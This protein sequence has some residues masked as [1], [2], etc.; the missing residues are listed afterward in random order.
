MIVASGLS[1]VFKFVNERRVCILGL[2]DEM[3]TDWWM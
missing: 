3:G 1:D 2:L